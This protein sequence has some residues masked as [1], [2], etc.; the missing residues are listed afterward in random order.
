M[1]LAVIVVLAVTAF[2]A[3]AAQLYCAGEP[4]PCVAQFVPE[5][6]DQNQYPGLRIECNSDGSCLLQPINGWDAYAPTCESYGISNECNVLDFYH[7]H[8]I[9]ARR[10]LQ[11]DDFGN[12]FVQRCP[13]GTTYND[14]LS[15]CT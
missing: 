3:D 6:L 13:P 8:P 15:V 12:C 7:P 14:S 4:N 9:N 10:F 2:G 5:P 1:F 11:C